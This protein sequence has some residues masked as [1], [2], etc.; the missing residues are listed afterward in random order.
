MQSLRLR[1]YSICL[2]LLCNVSRLDRRKRKSLPSRFCFLPQKV[3]K[4]NLFAPFR[5][6]IFCRASRDDA[7]TEMKKEGTIVPNGTLSFL[8]LFRL[9]SFSCSPSS[10]S[11]LFLFIILFAP[12]FVR[13]KST[14]NKEERIISPPRFGSSKKEQRTHSARLFQSNFVLIL[15]SQ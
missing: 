13:S 6:K 15:L 1:K 14:T 3:R 9:Y 8:S 11:F 12:P 2:K 7:R 4:F 10:L 5:R